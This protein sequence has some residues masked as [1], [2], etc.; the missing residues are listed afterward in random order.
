LFQTQN[1]ARRLGDPSLS[2]RPPLGLDL[3]PTEGAATDA[4]YLNPK[5]RW[6]ESLPYGSLRAVLG[7][8]WTL[9]PE[10][11]ADPYQSFLASAPR[12]A[13]GMPAGRNYGT[14][15]DAG[16]TFQAPLSNDRQLGLEIG[17]QYGLLFPGDVFTRAG[18]SSLPP[19]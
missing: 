2:G 8:L 18:G 10:P 5:V 15:F 14:E 6:R 11:V 3:F 1:A 19:V 12:N 16:L 4:F 9:A 17:G 13:F 7:V